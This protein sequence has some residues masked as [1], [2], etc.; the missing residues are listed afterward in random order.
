MFILV[1]LTCGSLK[2]AEK[3]AK[4][5]VKEKLIACANYFPISSTYSWK[6]KITTEKEY[7][8]LCKTTKKNFPSIKQVIQKVHSYELPAIVSI[9]TEGGSADYLRWIS[10]AL[11]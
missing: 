8:I 11:K 1:Y 5:L 6:G 9:P 10:L 4:T 2:E 7:L 3:I